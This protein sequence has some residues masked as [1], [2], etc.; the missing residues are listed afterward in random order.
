MYE[1]V[2]PAISFIVIFRAS[3]GD[4]ILSAYQH[5]RRLPSNCKFP[6]KS[7]EVCFVWRQM[8]QIKARLDVLFISGKNLQVLSTSLPN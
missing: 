4:E 7:R 8:R 2:Q 5:E 6:I 3:A 1:H